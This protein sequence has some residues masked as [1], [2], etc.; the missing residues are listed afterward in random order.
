M[1]YP[2]LLGQQHAQ[3]INGILN[4]TPSYWETGVI[5]QK[6]PKRS[7]RWRL[8]LETIFC[9]NSTRIGSN[10]VAHNRGKYVLCVEL[11]WV[12]NPEGVWVIF[13]DIW[14]SLSVSF[15][16]NSV[17]VVR[18]PPQGFWHLFFLLGFCCCFCCCWRS[19]N[20]FWSRQMCRC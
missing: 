15:Q 13:L 11:F 5:L 12:L 1:R 17:R 6:D 14:R 19:N 16:W 9:I 10:L 2:I 18:R 20:I 8:R 3:C 4:Q 7:F